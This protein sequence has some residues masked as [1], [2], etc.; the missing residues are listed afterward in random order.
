ME[1]KLQTDGLATMVKVVETEM[2][3][4]NKIMK[5]SIKDVMPEFLYAFNLECNMT[6]PFI[7]T[8]LVL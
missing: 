1:R 3:A 8:T 6:V 7:Q 4:A 5:M 2:K